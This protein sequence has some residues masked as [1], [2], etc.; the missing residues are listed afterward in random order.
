LRR[1]RGLAQDLALLTQ[2]PDL[3]T[4]PAQLITLA[5][6]EAIAAPA[7]IQVGALEALTDR[8]GELISGGVPERARAGIPAR[9]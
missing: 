3:T 2:I 1:N 9:G 8:S 7:G 6:G 4:Q 5:G